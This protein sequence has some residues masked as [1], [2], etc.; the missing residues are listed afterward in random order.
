MTDRACRYRGILVDGTAER[1]D[2]PMQP[3]V[4]CGL[5][6]LAILATA[7]NEILLQSYDGV[8]RL[9][10]ATPADWHAAFTLRAVG[11]FLVSSERD[12]NGRAKA[13]LIE[14]LLG[15]ECRLAEP[16]PGEPVSVQ[17]FGVAA[18]AIA[19]VTLENGILSFPTGVGCTYVVR[20]TTEAELPP[21][22]RF[23]AEPNRG[24]KQYGEAVLGK[25]RDF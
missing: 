13:V 10:A 6:P 24:P 21:A 12:K 15:N 18:Q 4:Q 8:I 14:S 22:T 1:V 19:S 20:P 17:A 5:E 25:P 16:W 7:V 2:L 9:F 23:A 3:F 11:G